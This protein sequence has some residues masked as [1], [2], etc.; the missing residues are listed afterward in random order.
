MLRAR[1]LACAPHRL[2]THGGAVCGLLVHDAGLCIARIAALHIGPLMRD[3]LAPHAE[4]G[5]GQARIQNGV[6]INL[7]ARR[8]MMRGL[9][10]RVFE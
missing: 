1:R 5:A 2:R 10:Q 4:S 8:L 7:D 6:R 9:Y 3:A